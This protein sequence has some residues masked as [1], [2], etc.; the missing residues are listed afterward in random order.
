MNLILYAKSK[1]IQYLSINNLM[2]S[3]KLIILYRWKNDCI[4]NLYVD[5][6]EQKV[7]LL[8]TL[9]TRRAAKCSHCIR[10]LQIP[11]ITYIV[12]VYIKN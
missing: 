10:M 11:I 5:A 4:T 6:K 9:Q 8:L 12:N 7:A 1:H 2:I 3:R